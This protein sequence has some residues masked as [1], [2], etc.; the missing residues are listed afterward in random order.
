M[1]QWTFG[2][3]EAARVTQPALAVLGEHSAPVFPGADASCCSRGC[4]T[5]SR[6]SSPA[7]R[8]CSTSSS[9]ARWPSP[10]S[11]SSRATPRRGACARAGE[12]DQQPGRRGERRAGGER[13]RDPRR[14]PRARPASHAPQRAAGDVA[15][16]LPRVRLGDGARRRQVADQ[17]VRGRGRGRE[18]EPR[19]HH[20]H[21]EHRHRARE[22]QQR[23]AGG[24]HAGDDEEAQMG[25]LGAARGRRTRARRRATRRSRARTASRRRR[26]SRAPRRT[27]RSRSRARR[28]RRLS[29]PARGRARG[30]PALPSAPARR[31]PG[32]CGCGRQRRE[33]GEAATPSPPAV[34]SAT[35]VR[36]ATSGEIAV[37]MPAASSGPEMNTS[38]SRS[39][40]SANAVSSRS[41]PTRPGS[42]ARSEGETGGTQSPATNA[43]TV[44]SVALAPSSTAT[45]KTV[46]LTAVNTAAKSSTRV[47]PTRSMTRPIHRRRRADAQ[48]RGGGDDPDLRVVEAGGPQQQDRRED[49]HPVREPPD[50]GGEHQRRDAGGAE[51]LAVPAQSHRR[52]RYG[53]SL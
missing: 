1:M 12:R 20:E 24:E 43:S 9:R 45:T 2:E 49:V 36:K 5:S 17:R 53:R 29:A 40:S 39:A 13:G 10:C 48:P 33:Y 19:H 27:R 26:A 4:P 22:R 44:T 31:V 35:P 21:G 32:S 41:R 51:D 14:A 23:E 15:D 25:A 16:D 3:E 11:R 30:S 42:S 8:T 7:R 18:T 6:S 50:E 47:C 52:G 28:A 46:P 38:S 34:C 37:A